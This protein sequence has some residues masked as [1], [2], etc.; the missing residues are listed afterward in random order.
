VQGYP[1]LKWFVNG[2][3]SEYKGG[4]TASEIE[5][6]IAKKTGPAVAAVSAERLEELKNKEKVFYVQVGAPSAEAE[7][8]AQGLDD[9][10]VVAVESLEG[11]AQGDLVAFRKFDEP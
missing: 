11:Y 3:E 2:K 4:R 9:L 6:W 10:V 7:Q 1:T 8:L 5:N